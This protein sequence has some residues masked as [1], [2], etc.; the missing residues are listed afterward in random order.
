MVHANHAAAHAGG[1]AVQSIF[2]WII[3]G[4]AHVFG[5]GGF[6]RRPPVLGPRQCFTVPVARGRLELVDS[7][8]ALRGAGQDERSMTPSGRNEPGKAVFGGAV[9]ADRLRRPGESAWILDLSTG[10]PPVISPGLPTRHSR[11]S[12]LSPG[13]DRRFDLQSC[14]WNW[15]KVRPRVRR[16]GCEMRTPVGRAEDVA[17]GNA[18]GRPRHTCSVSA[19]P[20]EPAGSRRRFAGR[21]SRLQVRRDASDR[22]FVSGEVWPVSHGFLDMDPVQSGS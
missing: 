22:L 18:A 16:V 11:C 17:T 4:R 12:R 9:A 7:E 13:R 6:P 21:P 20:V 2:L 10:T 3:D 5:G 8:A 1:G 15:G 19:W 14:S